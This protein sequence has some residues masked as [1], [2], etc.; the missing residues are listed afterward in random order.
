MLQVA[1]C[2]IV[3]F[4]PHLDASASDYT[5][6]I[7]DATY[8]SNCGAPKGNVTGDI[9]SQCD[10]K[11]HC[12]YNIDHTR[13]GDPCVDKIKHYSLTYKCKTNLYGI[14]NFI[15]TVGTQGGE[16]SKNTIYFN[17][18]DGIKIDKASYG[19]NCNVAGGN[20]TSHV[21]NQCNEQSGCAYKVDHKIIGDPAKNCSKDAQIIFRCGKNGKPKTVYLKHEAS[22]KTARFGCGFFSVYKTGK[23]AGTPIRKKSTQNKDKIKNSCN[24]QASKT[25]NCRCRGSNVVRKTIVPC[26]TNY[27]SN[28]TCSVKCNSC[29]VSC[30]S[31]G[32]TCFY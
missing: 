22:G 27:G 23:R 29:I 15:R 24:P 25:C 32:S 28:G 10:N 3:L 9:K 26:Y 14:T 31:L 6:E 13:L 7:Q 30:R 18:K 1:S 21:H 4:F 20:I 16:A 2:F 11:E 8:G 19:L 17:C 12:E 5:I